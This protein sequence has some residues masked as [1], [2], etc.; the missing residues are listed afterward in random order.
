MD[1]GK[2]TKFKAL[3][4]KRIHDFDLLPLLCVLQKAGYGPDD[5]LFTSNASICSQTGLIQD[6]EFLTEPVRAVVVLNFGL[7]G[8]QTPLPSYFMKRMDAMYFDSRAFEDFVG[9]FD[10]R[11]I[12]SYLM[13][14]LPEINTDLFNDWEQVKKWYLG[15][16]DLKSPGSLHWLFELVYP[17][18]DV[19]LEKSTPSRELTTTS[20]RLGR[21]VLGDDAIFGKKTM[22]PKKGVIQTKKR[23]MGRR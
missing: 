11:I 4:T 8:A 16:I 12:R 20:P 6:I 2:M 9:F 13:N 1:Q 18:L 7:L 23:A 5:I 14:L 22:K 19:M 15:M 10:H 21:T 3:I 17:E